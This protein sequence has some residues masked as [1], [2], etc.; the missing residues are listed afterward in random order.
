M[1]GEVSRTG[2]S[3]PAKLAGRLQVRVQSLTDSINE[4]QDR[5]LVSRRPDRTDRRRQ[6]VELTAAGIELLERD[7]T[8]RDAWLH[9]SMRDNLYELE[10]NLLMLVAPVL[11]RLAEGGEAARGRIGPAESTA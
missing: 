5:G 3:S 8:E 4:L 1:L 7:R 6:L 2:I 10:F 11:R 9:A